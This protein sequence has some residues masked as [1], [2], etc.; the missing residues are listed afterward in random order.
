MNRKSDTGSGLF[1]MEMI[2]AVFF[3]MLCASTCILAFAKS[4]HMS[5]RAK[6]SNGAVSAAQSVAEIWK[7]E[8]L[9]GLEEHFMMYGCEIGT[10]GQEMGFAAGSRTDAAAG[11]NR[12]EK[13][14]EILWDENWRSVQKE[15]EREAEYISVLDF[16]DDGNGRETL[17]MVFLWLP[18]KM[19]GQEPVF[20]LQVSRYVP[21]RERR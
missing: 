2:V 3:F 1:L 6:D 8:G 18:R 5:R 7:A 4:D 20:E 15:S 13:A 14:R 16:S 12:T 19:M 21:V 17:S 11:G 10:D 9:Q